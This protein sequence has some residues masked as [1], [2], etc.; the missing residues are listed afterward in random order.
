MFEGA[1]TPAV[2]IHSYKK[3][4]S[5]LEVGWNFDI[6]ESPAPTWRVVDSRRS[7]YTLDA[8]LT[9]AGHKSKVMVPTYVKDVAKVQ[10][11]C[12]WSETVLGEAKFFPPV[13]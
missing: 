1:K 6:H 10:V 12:A 8:F 4:R 3:G 9:K 11:Y 13:K 7:V 5:I 2:I